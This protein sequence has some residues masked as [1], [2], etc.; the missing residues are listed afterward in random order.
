MLLMVK[1]E[2]DKDAAFKL[3]DDKGVVAAYVP[4]KKD[5][6]FLDW[7][8][9][10][11]FTKL[12][13]AT[14]TADYKLTEDITLYAKFV[15]AGISYDVS[16]VKEGSNAGQISEKIT[17]TT[18]N[19]FAKESGTYTADTDFI[20]S[21]VPGGLTVVITAT[22]KTTAEITFSGTANKHAAADSI[23]NLTIE[24]KDSAYADG[25]KPEGDYYNKKKED[26]EIKFVD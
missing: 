13:S 10:K 11:E 17:A 8:T 24:W 19:E 12:A 21:N 23:K 15:K 3:Y 26:F 1:K 16:Y 2:F 18:V 25:K 9:D 22:S 7:Y 14:I 6:V 20:A 4:T 5:Y